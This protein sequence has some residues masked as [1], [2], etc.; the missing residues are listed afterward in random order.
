MHHA[1]APSSATQPQ[2]DLSRRA[3]HGIDV[4][5]VSSQ[6]VCVGGWC[7]AGWAYM[8][9]EGKLVWKCGGQEA[10]ASGRWNCQVDGG[11]KA[12]AST[13]GA[14]VALAAGQRCT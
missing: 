2:V 4:E 13:V 8:R 1:G 6:F 12:E 3:R 14:A 10:L 7:S 11:F 5:E 9:E